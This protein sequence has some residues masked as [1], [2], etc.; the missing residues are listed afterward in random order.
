[1]EWPRCPTK[2]RVIKNSIVPNSITKGIKIGKAIREA[3]EVGKDPI[4][5]FI[6]AAEGHKI[7]EG[8]IK[9][10][11]REEKGGFI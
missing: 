2:G 6:R 11:E 5:A 1:M 8:K 4:Q 10:W 3:K 9:E 7:F